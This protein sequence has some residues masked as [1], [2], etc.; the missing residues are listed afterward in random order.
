MRVGQS[1]MLVLPSS[2]GLA[3]S[4]VMAAAREVVLSPSNP[5]AK[6]LA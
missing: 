1:P 5:I 2:A 4:C 6:F 3:Q